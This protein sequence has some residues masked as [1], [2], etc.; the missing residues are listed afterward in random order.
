MDKHE[1]FGTHIISEMYD[2]STNIIND[3]E[4]IL[5]VLLRG[6]KLSG[7]KC[8]G[9]LCKKFTPCGFSAVLLLSESHA[10]VHTYPEKNALF[11]DAFTCGTSC[12]THIII[13]ELVK[14]LRVENCKTEIILRGKGTS[15]YEAI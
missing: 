14:S 11:A 5:N 4:L 13:D 2:I 6:V 8:E 15:N 10:S 1:F 7:A 12:K 3:N 9:V